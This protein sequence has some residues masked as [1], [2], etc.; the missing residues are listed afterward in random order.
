M[1]SR[2]TTHRRRETMNTHKVVDAV[3]AAAAALAVA[4]L[5]GICI[6]SVLVV[7]AAAVR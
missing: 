4:G 7:I 3:M 2:P 5:V 1:E 6:F